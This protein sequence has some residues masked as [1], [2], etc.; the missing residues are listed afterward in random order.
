[1]NKDRVKGTIDEVVGSAKR[2]AG[3]MAGNSKFQ[4]EGAAQQVKGK[5]ENTLGKT[6]DAVHEAIENTK[7]HV[8]AHVKLGLGHPTTNIDRCKNK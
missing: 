2:K 1:V 6:K 5:L 3:E 4:V 7:A 8:D